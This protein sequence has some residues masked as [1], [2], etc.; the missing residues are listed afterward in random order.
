MQISSLYHFGNC[1]MWVLHYSGTHLTANMEG[2]VYKNRERFS[3]T[4]VLGPVGKN[5]TLVLWDQDQ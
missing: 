5:M 3:I 2:K 1:E 4:L